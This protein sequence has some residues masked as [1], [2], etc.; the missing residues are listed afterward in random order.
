MTVLIGFEVLTAVVMK[1][2]LFMTVILCNILMG[3]IKIFHYHFNGNARS[4]F[5][6]IIH[7]FSVYMNYK[8]TKNAIFFKH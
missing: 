5:C 7:I 6:V 8:N 2:A 1:I 4:Y 3:I